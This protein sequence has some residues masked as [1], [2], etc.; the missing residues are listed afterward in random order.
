MAMGR[1]QRLVST[2]WIGRLRLKV[3]RSTQIV[4]TE[5]PLFE[6][7]L[8]HTAKRMTGYSLHLTMISDQPTDLSA[9]RAY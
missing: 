5:W 4:P 9:H 7:V 3:K 2:A 8:G 6:V 1:S